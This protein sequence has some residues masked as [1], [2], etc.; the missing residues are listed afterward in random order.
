[1]I[2]LIAFGSPECLLTL[3]FRE[4]YLRRPLGL[5][6]TVEDRNGE[7]AQFHIASVEAEGIV[8]TVVLKPMANKIARLRQMAV[9]PQRRNSGLGRELVRFAETV[10]VGHGFERIEMDARL[11]ARRFY[12]RLGYEAH[13]DTFVEVTIPHIKMAKDLSAR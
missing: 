4:R 11:T 2:Q 6:L 5:E 3:A 8:G 7:D 1:M 13:D 10:A 9:A 12:E